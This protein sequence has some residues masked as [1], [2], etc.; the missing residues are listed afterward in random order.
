M[1]KDSNFYF[2]NLGPNRPTPIMPKKQQT[3]NKDSL[4]EIIR[5]ALL[6]IAIVI[7]LRIF[8]A[9]PFVVSGES[10]Y[11]TFENKDY[12]IVDQVTY[13]FQDPERGDVIIFR[14]PKDPSR[15]FIKRII[16]LPGETIEF[17]KSD[18]IIKNHE[19][20]EGFVLDEPYVREHIPGLEPITLDG[21]EYYV[22]GD[23]RRESSDSRIWGPLP[24]NFLVGRALLRLFPYKHAAI[25]PGKTNLSTEENQ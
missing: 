16:A 5:F 1:K 4:W 9:Q 18:V 3:N 14:Y 6:A 24:K 23:N 20:P 25:F 13:K 11:P 12:L 21:D 17:N 15:F 19:S 8:I 22:M 2:K 10:M 7:P